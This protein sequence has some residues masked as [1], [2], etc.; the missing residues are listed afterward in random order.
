L[1]FSSIP[2]RPT[3]RYPPPPRSAAIN[4]LEKSRVL[5]RAGFRGRG[6]PPHMTHGTHSHIRTTDPAVRDLDHARSRSLAAFASAQSRRLAGSKRA[7]LFIGSLILAQFRIGAFGR[8]LGRC[9]AAGSRGRGA[10]A[11]RAIKG[12]KGK[13]QSD[14]SDWPLFMPATT[15]SP[16]HFRVQ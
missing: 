1:I 14:F 8:D 11:T 16:T 10:R 6:R 7:R 2:F 15:Y 12:K 4:G 3:T 9:R 5:M 13:G